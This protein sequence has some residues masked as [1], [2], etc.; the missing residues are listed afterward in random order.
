MAQTIATFDTAHT[1]TIHAAQLDYYGKR[2]VTASADNTIRIWDVSAAEPQFVAELKGHEGPVWQVCW[3]HPKFGNMLASCSYDRRVII[4]REQSPN[5]WQI[6]HKDEEHQG[7]VNSVAFSPWEFGLKLASASSDGT[8]AVLSHNQ[9]NTWSRKSFQYH[10]NG[11]N[12]VSWSPAAAPSA[13]LTG[14]SGSAM[15]NQQTLVAGGCDNQVRIWRLDEPTNEWIETHQMSDNVHSDWVR[16]VAWRPNTGV[17]TNTIA[18]C[19]EDQ[20]VI[21]WTQ[22]MEGSPWVNSQVLRLGAPCW[23]LSWSITG[24]VLAVASSDSR[25]TLFKES[26]D[27]RWEMINNLADETTESREVE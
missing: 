9:D 21:I 1:G 13:A 11:V 24:T 18:S 8:V 27:G 12:A 16:D 22:D 20:T 25:V 19:S 15:N 2:L 5:D 4:W 14:T 3:S 23:R 26:L 17:P 10:A 6:I 7:S